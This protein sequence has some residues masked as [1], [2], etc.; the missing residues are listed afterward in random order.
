MTCHAC[1]EQKKNKYATVRCKCSYGGI[2][3]QN[4]PSPVVGAN[5]E[6]LVFNN[7]VC[8]ECDIT[9]P[10]IKY[11]FVKYGFAKENEGPPLCFRHFA[12]KEYR[13]GNPCLYPA[14]KNKIIQHSKAVE[15]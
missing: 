13:K 3:P 15:Q 12:I 6:H 14:D 1:L 10:F 2:K 9:D 11:G 8:P 4:P 7:I 5:E